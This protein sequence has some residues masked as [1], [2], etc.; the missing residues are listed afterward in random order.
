MLSLKVNLDD[1]IWFRMLNYKYLNIDKP[2]TINLD[3]VK[4]SQVNNNITITYTE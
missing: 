4:Y 2:K 1:L 3:T